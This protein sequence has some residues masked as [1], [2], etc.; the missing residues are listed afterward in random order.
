MFCFQNIIR[1]A[2]MAR[3]LIVLSCF[4]SVLF[5]VPSQCGC[6]EIFENGTDVV[7]D[8]RVE[9]TWRISASQPAEKHLEWPAAERSVSQKSVPNALIK[10]LVTAIPVRIL[11]CVL[12]E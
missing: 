2:S 8:C 4:L 1:F 6:S 9:T 11:H 3:A 10:K 7:T 12:R 5:T